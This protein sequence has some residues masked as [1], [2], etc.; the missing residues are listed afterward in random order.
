MKRQ[1]IEWMPISVGARPVPQPVAT[2]LVWAGAFGGALLLVL[3][4]NAVVGTDRPGLV[5]AVLSLLA[6]VLGLCARFTAAPGTAALCWLL[7]N[8]FA[9]P[10]MGVLTWAGQRDT[11]WLACLLTAALVGTGC[12]RL[13]HA[14]AAYRRIPTGVASQGTPGSDRGAGPPGDR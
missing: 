2:P 6:A 11:F 10:P 14:R 8:G 5:L 4:L 9:I 12:A 1:R 3:V 13:N 7:L